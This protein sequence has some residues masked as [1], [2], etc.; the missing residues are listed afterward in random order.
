MLPPCYHRAPIVLPVKNGKAFGK[1]FR[2]ASGK[3]FERLPLNIGLAHFLVGVGLGFE[4]AKF[5]AVRAKTSISPENSALCAIKKPPG[6]VDRMAFAVIESASQGCRN[7]IKFP[8]VVQVVRSRDSRMVLGIVFLNLSYRSIVRSNR[9]GC[10][11][12][13]DKNATIFPRPSTRSSVIACCN[14]S[15]VGQSSIAPD[16]FNVQYHS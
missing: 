3:A 6:M 2:K 10:Q 4:G 9:S 5:F 11:R 14:R 15:C 7:C 12:H 8:K 1:A 16:V 13:E